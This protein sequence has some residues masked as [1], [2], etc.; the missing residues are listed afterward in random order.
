MCDDTPIPAHS[1]SPQYLAWVHTPYY[2]RGGV[3]A[4]LFASPALERLTKSPWWVVPMLWLPVAAAFW[5]PYAASGAATAGGAALLAAA[6]LVYWSLLE[7]G[8][9]R[10]VFHID[11]ALPPR[12]PVLMTLHFLAHGVHHRVPM[13]RN[14]LVM[15]PAA[16]AVIAAGVYTVLHACLPPGLFGGEAQWAAFYGSAL[17]G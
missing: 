13:D 7:Y 8:L 2:F 1:H 3:E 15:P 11:G 10:L 16:A 6:G 14:R 12:A 17:V 4:R 5:A 9:H